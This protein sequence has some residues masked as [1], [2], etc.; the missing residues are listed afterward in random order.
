MKRYCIMFLALVSMIILTLSPSMVQAKQVHPLSYNCS[1]SCFGI[2]YWSGTTYGMYDLTQVSNPDTTK[3]GTNCAYDRFISLNQGNGN[4]Q[5][6]ILVGIEKVHATYNWC[7]PMTNDTLKYFEVAFKNG[8]G[9]QYYIHCANVPSADVNNNMAWK[10]APYTNGG[11]GMLIQLF[12]QTYNGTVNGTSAFYLSY[13]EGASHTYSQIA[14]EDS[15]TGTVPSSHWVWGVDW[16]DA[17]WAT[18]DGVLHY[19]TTD[20]TNSLNNWGHNPPAIG[21]WGS[22][23]DPFG[24]GGD[25]K[26]CIYGTGETNCTIGG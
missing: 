21:Y 25:F 17:Q 10:I 26:S 22:L 6:S 18:G 19:H 23:P 14:R 15:I 9:N 20:Y 13:A 1:S 2:G 16:E 11:G 12:T 3:C 7:G 4:T 5:Y 8:F 24:T